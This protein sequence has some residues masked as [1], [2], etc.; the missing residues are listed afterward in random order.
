MAIEDLNCTCP[1]CELMLSPEAEECPV[2]GLRFAPRQRTLQHWYLRSWQLWR[3][4]SVR[5]TR[6]EFYAFIIPNTLLMIWWGKELTRIQQSEADIFSYLFIG[7]LG[8]YHLLSV[9]PL[10][11]LITRRLHDR[12]LDWSDLPE[13]IKVAM[14]DFCDLSPWTYL[15]FLEPM[16]WLGLSIYVPIRELLSD[17][18][19]GP[20]RFGPSI[21]YPR[22][23]SHLN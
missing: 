20:N 23:N 14:E 16:L 2:C 21:R 6:R 17:T 5:A 18:T 15:S 13:E 22:Y 7:L 4:R 19:P 1:E 9:I 11:S 10:F 12:D 8:L 3:C